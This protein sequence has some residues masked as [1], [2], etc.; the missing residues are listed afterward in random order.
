MW[1]KT[2]ATQLLNIK[3]P[4]IQGPFGGSFSSVKLL[5]T[6]SN[7]GGLG[8]FGLNS[9]SHEQILEI[10]SAIKK[11][12]SK[13]YN[14][15]LWV[16]LKSDPVHRFKEQDY[17]AW[18]DTYDPIFRE[19]D[20]SIPAAMP[21]NELNFEDQLE[22]VLKL[23]PPVVSFIFGIPPLEAIK[24]LKKNGTTIIAAAT[25]I[26]EALLLNDTEVD[27]MIATGKEAGGHRPSFLNAAENS[28]QSTEDLLKLILAKLDKPIIAAGG[29]SN[30]EIAW[31]YLEMGAGAVQL[32]TAFLATHESGA[33]LEHKELLLSKNSYSTELSKIFT[34][35]LARTITNSFSIDSLEKLIH[36]PYPLQSKL[37]SPLMKKYK[38]NGW[39]EKLAFWAGEPSAI[40]TKR[41]T[42]SLFESLIQEIEL[43]ALKKKGA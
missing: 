26:E 42:E 6:V 33:T 7:L 5:S 41:S 9:F 11:A 30:G 4:I 17:N 40:L 24:E 12:T 32:G 16:P 3:Y 43:L 14:L 27:I 23:R 25:T 18:K 19:V 39:G 22:A 35:R 13:P 10:G 34:G 36:A 21:K 8:S 15:N 31:K 38:E 29:I 37:L 2:K 28:L 1:N 20:L